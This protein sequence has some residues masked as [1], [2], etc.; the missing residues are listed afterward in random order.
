MY[1]AIPS[2]NR[3]IKEKEEKRNRTIHLEHLRNVRPTLTAEEGAFPVVLHHGK[4]EAALENKYTEIE[5]ENRILLEKIAGIF[6]GNRRTAT[7]TISANAVNKSPRSL[8]VTIRR[9]RLQDIEVS[10][11]RLLKRLQ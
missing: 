3:H 8:N 7:G 5:R 1:R 2:Q 4:K 10:N 6:T 9:K 11:A